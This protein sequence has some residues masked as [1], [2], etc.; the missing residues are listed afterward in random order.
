MLT[1]ALFDN[2]LSSSEGKISFSKNFS[3]AFALGSSLTTDLPLWK[4]FSAFLSGA[5]VVGDDGRGGEEAVSRFR[6]R[7][8]FVDLS[9]SFAGAVEDMS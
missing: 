9:A 6:A 7:G 5:L 3:P 4:P 8:F 1:L 2:L